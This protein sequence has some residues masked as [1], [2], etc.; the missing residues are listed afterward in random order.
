MIAL[1][2]YGLATVLYRQTYLAPILLF[3]A[4]VVVGSRGDGGPL[5]PLFA[6][7]T[8]TILVCSIWLTVIAIDAEDVVQERITMVNAGRRWLPLVANIVVIL[9]F[10]LVLA[11]FGLVF[12]LLVGVRPAS[13]ADFIVGLVA[14]WSAACVGV[15]VGMFCSRLF[16]PRVG[17]SLLLAGAAAIALL[18]VPWLPPVNRLIRLLSSGESAGVILPSV[19]VSAV[20]SVVLLVAA[21]LVARRLR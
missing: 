19:A 21:I 11:V 7:W 14:Q 12:P 15:V 20:A 4:V 13:G 18:L 9:S 10:A 6:L 3:A 1:Y 5:L 17:Y 8:G 2:R 16:I